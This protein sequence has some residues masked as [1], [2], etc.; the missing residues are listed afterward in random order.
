MEN[1]EFYID[2]NGMNGE[3]ISRLNGKVYFINGAIEGEKVIAKVV[4]ENK[5]FG[6]AQTEKML[7]KCD[8][9]CEPKC[10]YYGICGGCNMQHI[11]YEKQLEIKT[12]NV[13]NL[14]NKHKL[15]ASV[16]MCQ[17]GQ[18]FE[19]RNK[20]TMYLSKNNSLG[21]YKE[22]S[23][24]LCEINYCCLVNNDF[25]NLINKLNNFFKLNKEFNTFVLKGLSIRQINDKY[26]INLISTKKIILTKLQNYLKLNKINYALYY[27]INNKKNSN[28]PEYPCYFV[29]GD[30][31]IFLNEY[32]IKYP[33]YPMSFLQVN[34]QVKKLVYDEIISRVKGYANV[35]DAYS[36]AGLLSAILAKNNKNVVAVEIDESASKAC[37]QLCRQNDIKNVKSI[38]GDCANILPQLLQENKYDFIVLDP[39]RAGVDQSILQEI[40]NYKIQNVIYLSCNPATLT[41]DLETLTNGGYKITFAKPY[42]MFPQTSN[43]ET[44]VQ[45]KLDVK[46]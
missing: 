22:N 8:N 5:N 13:Q 29:A 1:Y 26:I 21:F 36:G 45:L 10:K 25:N 46:D 40:V 24:E 35:I 9:R 42:D 41:R 27:C 23:R 19:Y 32:S 20:I 39:A 34:N 38:C 16:S 17:G 30:E 31:Q 11:K 44:L 2:S 4:K 6:Y 15:N 28:I 12:Q 18:D 43:V 3:G 7:N 37:E 33:V 14:F